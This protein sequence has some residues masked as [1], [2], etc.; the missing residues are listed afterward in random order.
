MIGDDFPPFTK[1]LLDQH[2][3]D[4]TIC[5][6]LQPTVALLCEVKIHRSDCSFAVLL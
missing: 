6:T 1:V 2:V 4:G 3:Q 5:V